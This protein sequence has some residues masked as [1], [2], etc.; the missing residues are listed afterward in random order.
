[1]EHRTVET[2]DLIG[3]RPCLDFVN[4]MNWHLSA[5]PT[6]FLHSY[7][8][9][10][11]WSERTEVL[12]S[13]QAQRLRAQAQDRPQEAE[14]IYE[15]AIGFRKALFHLFLA[16]LHNEPPPQEDLALV[17]QVHADMLTHL[18]LTPVPGGLALSW[19]SEELALPLWQIAQTAGA[20][21][22]SAEMA[23][24]R[25]CA[26]QTCGWLFLDKSKN[27]SRK[28][29]ASQDCGNRN[30]VRRFKQRKLADPS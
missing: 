23:H 13:E 17:N 4:T 3:E 5:A 26:D 22:T 2:M 14:A 9:L 29:C 16:I 12:S 1:M 30:R 18:S 8:D 10:L 19:S 25:V 28:W 7:S 6:E 27:H 11:T 24:V 15:L 21:L 20:L